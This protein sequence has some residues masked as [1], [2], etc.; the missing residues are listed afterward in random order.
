MDEWLQNNREKAAQQLTEAKGEESITQHLSH[1][2]T[3]NS[4]EE[5][6]E[7]EEND[8]D[9]SHEPTTR[10]KQ[11]MAANIKI[12]QILQP[13]KKNLPQV[14]GNY[15][16]SESQ[17]T[18]TE[19][20]PEKSLQPCKNRRHTSTNYD[21]LDEHNDD[22]DA[23]SLEW[24]DQDHMVAYEEDSHNLNLSVESIT[25]MDMT[26]V[27]RYNSLLHKYDASLKENQQSHNL[28]RVYKFSQLLDKLPPKSFDMKPELHRRDRRRRSVWAKIASKCTNILQ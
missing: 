12:K 9:N 24:D 10:Y 19:N 11:K 28:Q 22:D 7:A 1:S 20:S 2:D 17:P 25:E 14:D 3:T 16:E 27:H 21:Y 23:V 26:K 18:T 13:T 5:Y 6:C 15:T 4:D 8:I